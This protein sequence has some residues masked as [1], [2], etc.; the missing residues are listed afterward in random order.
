MRTEFW[1][2]WANCRTGHA[3]DGRAP[4]IGRR[5]HAA[6]KDLV[7]AQEQRAKRFELSKIR[8]QIPA[9]VEAFRKLQRMP[10][11]RKARASAPQVMQLP[12]VCKR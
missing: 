4:Y 7:A 11:L 10:K 2:D 1:L 3:V 5:F 12:G 6:S 8:I 9:A